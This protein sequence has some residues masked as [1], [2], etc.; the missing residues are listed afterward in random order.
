M[1]LLKSLS[2]ELEVDDELGIEIE[3]YVER[4]MQHMP[5]SFFILLEEALRENEHKPCKNKDVFIKTLLYRWKRDES[6]TLGFVDD[7]FERLIMRI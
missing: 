6:K 3:E 5:V 1:K 4:S 7:D 2:V